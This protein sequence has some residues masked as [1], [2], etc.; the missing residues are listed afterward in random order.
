M[1]T[2]QIL[3]EQTKAVVDGLK[4]RNFKDAEL[5]VEQVI[6][7]DK[8]RRETQNILDSLKAK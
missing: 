5:L 1:L 2:L 3:R 7:N 6:E 4:K 8:L